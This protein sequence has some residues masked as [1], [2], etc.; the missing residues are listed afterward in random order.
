MSVPFMNTDVTITSNDSTT[1]P[2]VTRI[3]GISMVCRLFADKGDLTFSTA[4]NEAQFNTSNPD[5]DYNAVGAIISNSNVAIPT[6][7]VVVCGLDPAA[8][9]TGVT[10]RSLMTTFNFAPEDDNSTLWKMIAF[11]ESNSGSTLGL[12]LL[13]ADTDTDVTTR[14]VYR[15]AI[16]CFADV[17]IPVL[18]FKELRG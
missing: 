8:T 15:N 17:C 18:L 2:K 3:S 10:F 16:W 11:L 9:L 6:T 7:G 12:T 5:Q 4:K 14:E 13:A 1:T